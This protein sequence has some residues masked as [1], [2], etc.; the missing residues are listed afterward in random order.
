VRDW[1]DRKTGALSQSLMHPRLHAEIVEV[2]EC[3]N[4]RSIESDVAGMQV[5]V[6]KSFGQ[7]PAAPPWPDGKAPHG[8]NGSSFPWRTR[9]VGCV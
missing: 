3:G 4:V 6:R 7:A 9:P 1:V 2:V 8:R 5:A